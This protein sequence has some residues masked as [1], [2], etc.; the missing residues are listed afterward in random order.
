MPVQDELYQAL[1]RAW[2]NETTGT[3]LRKINDSSNFLLNI[4]QMYQNLSKVALDERKPLG[5]DLY[6]KLLYNIQFMLNDLLELR[7]EKILCAT[8]QGKKIDES[9]LLDL[10]GEYYRS[11]FTAYKGVNKY[12]STI[13]LPEPLTQNESNSPNTPNSSEILIQPPIKIENTSIPVEMNISNTAVPISES[14]IGMDKVENSKNEITPILNLDK[15]NNNQP[16]TPIMQSTSKALIQPSSYSTVRIIKTT[17]PLVGEDFGI[18]G[19]FKEEDIIYI[20]QRNA[21]ILIEEKV[22]KAFLH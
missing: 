18:Y 10:E 3:E 6:K 19:P 16:S 22:A 7:T 4:R 8:K 14:P 1:Y 17:P 2:K 21:E 20:P 9:I 12:R 13:F 11:L 5:K 15:S